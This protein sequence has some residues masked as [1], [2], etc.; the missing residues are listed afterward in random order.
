MSAVLIASIV[1]ALTGLAGAAYSAWAARQTNRDKLNHPDW[2]TFAEQLETR[3]GRQDAKI[4]DLYVEIGKLRH[5]LREEQTR[6]QVTIAYIRRLLLWVR[7]T[8]PGVPPPTPPA[9]ISEE[10]SDLI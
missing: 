10:L 9:L 7:E 2:P 6:T 5:L 3:M 1:T 4:D 8:S